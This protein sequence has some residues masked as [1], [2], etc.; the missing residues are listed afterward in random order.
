M[1]VLV[2]HCL[3]KHTKIMKYQAAHDPRKPWNSLT[4]AELDEILVNI[5]NKIKNAVESLLFSQQEP[6]GQASRELDH[7]IENLWRHS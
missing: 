6:T 2:R 7:P 1:W 5:C 3:Y 4:E